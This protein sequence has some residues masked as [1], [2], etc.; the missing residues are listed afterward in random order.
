[1]QFGTKKADAGTQMADSGEVLKYLR[2]FREGDNEVRF[3]DEVD[4]WISFSEHYSADN[5]SFPCTM[6]RSTCPGCTSE[7]E[8]VQRASRKYATNVKLVGNGMVLPFRIPMSLAK[9]LF[10]RAERNGTIT[11]R[12]YIVMR[13]GKGLDTEYD[14]EQG[15]RGEVDLEALREQAMDIESV[16]V[17]AYEEVWGP[18]EKEEEEPPFDSS[19]EVEIDEATIRKMK[20][21]QLIALANDN[22]IEIDEDGSK[23][24]ILDSILE[25]A[26]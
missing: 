12:D 2:N 6:D 8:K 14:L 5:K 20:R 23:K 16:L 18:L 3:I 15:D 17:T 9:K 4:D 24:E 26:V 13:E 1:M 11:N 7:I 25:A 19:D 22:D 21:D 10:N